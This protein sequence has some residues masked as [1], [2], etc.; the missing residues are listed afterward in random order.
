MSRVY[1]YRVKPGGR[2]VDFGEVRNA[3]AFYVVL[4][5]FLA[6]RHGYRSAFRSYILSDPKAKQM[7]ETERVVGTLP[8]QSG[9]LL[10]STFDRVWFPAKL[11]PEL[12]DALAWAWPLVERGVDDSIPRVEQTVRKLHREHPRS[13]IAFEH[14]VACP[15]CAAAEDTEGGMT[16]ALGTCATALVAA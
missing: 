2:M 6:D 10:A 4:W 15:W 14:S 7:I 9:L 3:T 1:V 8:R 5:E 11:L 16:A 12:A 13:G